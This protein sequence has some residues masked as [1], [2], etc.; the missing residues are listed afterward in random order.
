MRGSRVGNDKRG[1]RGD[2]IDY[3]SN[4]IELVEH[5]P[6]VNNDCYLDF[7]SQCSLWRERER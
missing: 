7:F 6:Y 4:D 1:G 2:Y 5:D 3:D